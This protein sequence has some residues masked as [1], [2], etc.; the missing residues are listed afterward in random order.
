LLDFS[1]SIFRLSRGGSGFGGRSR[2]A[3]RDEAG[4]PHMSKVSVVERVI[5]AVLDALISGKAMQLV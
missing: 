2:Q 5:I 3:A 1:C 4:D